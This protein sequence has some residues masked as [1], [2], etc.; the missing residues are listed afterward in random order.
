MRL[1]WKEV[2]VWK[3]QG[4]EGFP[5]QR[6]LPSGNQETPREMGPHCRTHLL[7]ICL[8]ISTRC[9]AMR[10]YAQSRQILCSLMDCSPPGPSVLGT[11]PG[12]NTGVGSH[13][14]LQR[15]FLAQGLN[16][17]PALQANSLLCEPLRM[18]FISKS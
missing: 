15:I 2:G 18:V 9:C 7:E 10:A 12:K 13:S 16:L 5:R 11:F 3:L 17:S 8:P 6:S 1:S 4:E 14:L